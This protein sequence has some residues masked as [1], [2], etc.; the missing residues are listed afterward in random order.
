VARSAFGPHEVVE[1]IGSGGMGEVYRAR[2]ARLER[3]FIWSGASRIRT[4]RICRRCAIAGLLAFAFCP[5]AEPKPVTRFQV[6]LSD[7]EILRN[8]G[9]PVVDVSRDGRQLIFNTDSGVVVRRLDTL[10]KRVIPG[11]EMAIAGPFFAADGQSIGYYN[12]DGVLQRTSIGGG[13]AMTLV[14]QLPD[15][16]FGADWTDEGDI[17]YG[18]S[19]GIYR[20]SA[21]GGEAALV[22]TIE[23]GEVVYGAQLLPD[24][25]SMLFSLG[26]STDWDNSS[27]FVQSLATGDRKKLIAGGNDARY[28][29]TGHLLYVFEDVQFAAA[30]D[31]NS[32]T[33]NGGSVPMVEGLVRASVTGAGNYAVA[34]NGT[35]IYLNGALSFGNIS[36]SW[37]YRDGRE[38]QLAQLEPGAHFN[39]RISPDGSQL[40]VTIDT[41]QEGSQDI[42]IYDLLRPGAPNRITFD[43][44]IDMRPFPN[45][46][47]REERISTDGG[48]EPLWGP[49]GDELFIGS[50]A[51]SS[52]ER[53]A[54]VVVENWFE[55]LKRRV[56]TD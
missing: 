50:A 51:Q 11:T 55:E 3:D 31:L 37:V 10:E 56:P 7:S 26:A 21:D 20:V 13:A 2:D 48:V 33:V 6:D 39:P 38:E 36:L 25:D 14:S 49:A 12:F 27:I 46:S 4:T 35:L 42:W 47:G 17:F 19:D 18:Q 34:D 30:F 44:G 8:T 15:N 45:V 1:Q 43:R 22:V 52:M 29:S 32:L 5:H 24:G 40:A 16:L 53:I 23:E 9:R 54:I 41:G 28:V